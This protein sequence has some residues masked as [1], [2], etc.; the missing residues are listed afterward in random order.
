MNG[1]QVN[2]PFITGL[3]TKIYSSEGF[4][5]IDTSPDIQIYYNGYNVIKISISERLQNKVCGLCGNFNGDLTDDY[6]T[7]RGK[8]VVSSVVLAQ[9]WKT[10]G[11]QKRWESPV[12]RLSGPSPPVSMTDVDEGGTSYSNT[13]P[14]LQIAKLKIFGVFIIQTG[15]IISWT[16]EEVTR[17]RW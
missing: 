5:V 6:V 4:L 3:A 8:P 14:R 9:S 12:T 7:L 10:N 11:M 15:T 13:L 1:T 2:V 16:A 17:L